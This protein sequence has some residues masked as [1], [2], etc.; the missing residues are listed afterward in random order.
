[1][2]DIT[3]IT[4]NDTSDSTVTVVSRHCSRAAARRTGRRV[5]ELTYHRGLGRVRTPRIGDR[6]GLYTE[7]S[8]AEYALVPLS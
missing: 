1:M 4:T 6:L 5:V 7:P 2:A 3:H 8:G